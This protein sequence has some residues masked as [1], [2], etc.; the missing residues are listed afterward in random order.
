MLYQER[1]DRFVQIAEKFKLDGLLSSTENQISANTEKTESVGEKQDPDV[2]ASEKSKIM[3]TD[4]DFSR[5]VPFEEE[6]QR[7]I[8]G[9][10]TETLVED[11]DCPSISVDI[12]NRVNE[13]HKEAETLFEDTITEI[14]SDIEDFNYEVFEEDI[15]DRTKKI[16]NIKS[17]PLVPNIECS[18]ADFER[19]FQEK[20]LKEEN[21]WLCTVCERTMKQRIDIKRHFE[22]HVSGLSFDCTMCEKSFLTSQA[23]TAHRRKN[24]KTEIRKYNLKNST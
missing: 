16:M 20:V 14:D 10:L 6:I 22:N 7:E 21:F 23:L 4:T 5:N 1:L 12:R 18:N 3:E 9:A 11:P 13:E 15:P 19:I 8:E 24:H 2:N 17:E